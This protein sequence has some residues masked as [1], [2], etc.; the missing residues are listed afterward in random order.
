M[1]ATRAVLTRFTLPLLGAAIL[2]VAL[3]SHAL[4]APQGGIG[5]GGELPQHLPCQ[6]TTMQPYDVNYGGGFSNSIGAYDEIEVDPYQ[7]WDPVAQVWCGGFQTMGRFKIDSQQIFGTC[8]AP[9][10]KSKVRQ[11]RNGVYNEIAGPTVSDCDTWHDSGWVP[12]FPDVTHGS[13]YGWANFTSIDSGGAAIT[14]T[15]TQ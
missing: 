15:H 10:V 5:H 14:S 7:R 8:N 3:S 11:Y 2:I 13:F 9:N 4:A 1:R 12:G 6:S